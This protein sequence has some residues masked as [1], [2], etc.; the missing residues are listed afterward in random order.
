MNRALVQAG[1]FLTLLAVSGC[2]TVNQPGSSATVPLKA[3]TETVQSPSEPTPSAK[4]PV[5]VESTSASFPPELMFRLMT[6]EIA[7]QRGDTILAAQAYM[8]AAFA[9]RDVKIVEQAMRY[10]AMNSNIDMEKV[11]KLAELWVELAPDLSTSHQALAMIQLQRGDA[12]TALEQLEY[13]LANFETF[14]FN[15]VIKLL[16]RQPNQKLA[17]Q[18][19]A[20]LAKARPDNAEAHFAHAHLAARFGKPEEALQAN[21][22][23]IAILPDWRN[24]IML[25]GRL[26]QMLKRNDEAIQLLEGYLSGT[27]SD[28]ADMRRV[29]ARLLLRSQ[30]IEPAWQ[31][32]QIILQQQPDDEASRYLYAIASLELDK[33]ELAVEELTQLAEHG[34]HRD[35][36]R[37][38]LGRIGEIDK[39]PEVALTWYRRVDGGQFILSARLREAILISQQG[40]YDGALE[41]LAALQSEDESPQLNIVLVT[42]DILYRAQ[43][44]QQAITLYSKRLEQQID[45][46]ALPLYYS[47]AMMF[48]KTG[49]LVAMEQDLRTVLSL[50]EDNASALNALGYNLANRGVRLEEALAYLERAMELQPGSGAITDSI[51]WLYFRM[52]EHEK[53][54]EYLLQALKISFDVE[55]AA[56]LGEVLWALG[57]HERA[58]HVWQKALENDPDHAVLTETIERL[59]K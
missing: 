21:E 41:V 32:Y 17:L 11:S 15:A 54:R 57:E 47:R 36:A 30:K 50:D 25:Q 13:L 10:G 37:F 56:H 16:S 9:T 22:R 43:R 40:D 46:D 3:S 26:L 45:T 51:G 53:A 6:A 31:Q 19:V 49:D 44:Y 20:E 14:D 1:F 55:V 4:P 52:G 23:A 5:D 35:D 29:L 34:A 48:D 18:V 8:D 33:K 24:A 27:M 12:V 59:D 42:G 38:Q 7:A 39:Q 28:D 2:T 58:R